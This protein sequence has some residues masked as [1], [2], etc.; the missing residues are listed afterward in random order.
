M[1]KIIMWKG[2]YYRSLEYC[3][4][5][6]S[7]K[8]VEVTATILGIHESTPYKVDYNIKAKPNWEL[9]SCRIASQL[10]EAADIQ[11]FHRSRSGSW[12]RNKQPVEGAEGCTDIDISVSPLTN[13]FP[14][15]RLDLQVDQDREIKVL[16]IDILNQAIKPAT[17]RYTKLSEF[18]YH[19]QNVPNDF[20]AVITVDQLGLVKEYPGLFTQLNR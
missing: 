2:I 6:S 13:S 14:I 11:T 16:Y 9:V 3:E 5:N 10:G 17:Q 15:N 19:Y 18:E 1:K 7:D 8:A 12:T 20:E 4:I